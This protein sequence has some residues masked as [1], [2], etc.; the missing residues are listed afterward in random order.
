MK[1]LESPLMKKLESLHS[2]LV[3]IKKK[4]ELLLPE[5]VFSKLLVDLVIASVFWMVLIVPKILYDYDL[6]ES[7]G[8]ILLG[9]L[10]T[11]KIIQ[12]I[13]EK[14]GLWNS[15]TRGINNQ[16]CNLSV[17]NIMFKRHTQKTFL[18]GLI[19]IVA[20]TISYQFSEFQMGWSMKSIFL[21][22]FLLMLRDYLLAYRIKNG[23]YGNNEYE[24]LEI[25]KFI[26]SESS[27]IDFTDGGKHKKIFSEDDLKD[28]H[29]VPKELQEKNV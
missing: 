21:V 20:S 3:V 29:L 23:F 19:I 12:Q 7:W 17:V 13:Y 9:L 25:I 15:K 18:S 28:L 6:L 14:N 24:A 11:G 8:I 2:S 16:Y 1:K 26:L 10:M 27:K 5:H 22:L 4:L